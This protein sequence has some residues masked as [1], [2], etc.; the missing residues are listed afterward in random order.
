MRYA[1]SEKSGPT[2]AGMTV[3][4]CDRNAGMSD[5]VRT[6]GNAT[7][8]SVGVIPG[9]SRV[10]RRRATCESVM[11]DNTVI[12]RRCGQCVEGQ[13]AGFV[14]GNGR[15]GMSFASSHADTDTHDPKSN[16]A[17]PVSRH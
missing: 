2:D 11:E 6:I 14:I 17:D 5:G 3:R 1:C 15:T 8:D 7:D 16:S 10:M 13:L 4:G 9:K 12:D